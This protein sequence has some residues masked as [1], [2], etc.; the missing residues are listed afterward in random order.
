VF[1]NYGVWCAVQ[2]QVSVGFTCREGSYRVSSLVALFLNHTASS[3]HTHIHTYVHM[4]LCIY[5]HTRTHTNTY[6]HIHPYIYTCIH[7][8]LHA[9]LYARTCTLRIYIHTYITYLHVCTYII[10]YVRIYV[11]H[12]HTLVRMY[13]C[14]FI[15]S[16]R[17]AILSFRSAIHSFHGSISVS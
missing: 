11:T 1:S 4:H 7:A 15:H 14:T 2:N 6:A 8:Y 17:S 13:V 9:C 12:T 16:F 5:I 10:P 3:K